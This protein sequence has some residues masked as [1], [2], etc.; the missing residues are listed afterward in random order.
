MKNILYYYLAGY[1]ISGHISIRCN[2][3]IRIVL[4]KKFKGPDFVQKHIY[5][6]HG[7]KVDE[8]CMN[9]LCK[10]QVLMYIL[11][12]IGYA[13]IPHVLRRIYWMFR[14]ERKPFFNHGILIYK[15]NIKITDKIEENNWKFK[16]LA[17][18]FL[19]PS[20]FHLP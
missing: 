19:F 1:R 4:G 18:Q 14:C 3:N 10:M 16:V 11:N 9:I 7:E 6:K 5:N 13:K 2:P 8:V 20:L 12:Y 15:W 17:F